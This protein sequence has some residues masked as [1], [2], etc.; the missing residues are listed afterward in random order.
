MASIPLDATLLPRYHSGRKLSSHVC[1]VLQLLAHAAAEPHLACNVQALLQ[2]RIKQA[3]L[4]RTAL[5]LPSQHTNVYRL[6]N[7][8][9]NCSSKGC[10]GV[11]ED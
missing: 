7:R 10:V 5:G 11:S 6:V 3:V 4:L 1:R 8:Y 9:M 2:L